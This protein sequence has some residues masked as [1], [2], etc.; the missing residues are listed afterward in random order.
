MHLMKQWRVWAVLALVPALA[1]MGCEGTTGDDEGDATG[2]GD[3]M[4]GDAVTGDTGGTTGPTYRYIL[5]QEDPTNLSIT[6]CEDGD[7][8]PGADIDAV[9]LYR[10]TDVISWCEKITWRTGEARGAALCKD[11]DDNPKDPVEANAAAAMG[12]ADACTADFS[13]PD[14]PVLESDKWIWL[15]GGEIVCELAADAAIAEGDNIVV[16]EVFS[17]AKEDKKAGSSIESYMI[18]VADSADG[19]WTD[20]GKGTG[21]A[22]VTVPKL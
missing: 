13:T 3:I 1:L 2:S 19:P 18:K 5:V 10:G 6:D 21:I 11:K 16:Y 4:T 14:C 22:P 8:T 9:A 12:A 7:E 20:L 17:Q 15:N